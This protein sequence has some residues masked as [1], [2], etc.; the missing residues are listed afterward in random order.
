MIGLG[1]VFPELG[2]DVRAAEGDFIAVRPTWV[3]RVDEEIEE[4]PDD[5]EKSNTVDA[6]D[7][8]RAE[9]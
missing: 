7:L 9:L 2:E 3:A 8:M 6:E 5:D 1:I 4:I